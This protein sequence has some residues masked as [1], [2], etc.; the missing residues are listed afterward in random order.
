MTTTGSRYLG[1]MLATLV[2]DCAGVPHEHK[3]ADEIAR[4]LAE[5]SGR[6]YLMGYHDPWALRRNKEVWVAEPR[7]SDDSELATALGQSL[8]AHPEFD[9]A[10]LFGRMRSF[11]IDRVSI[12]TDGPAY[13]HGRTLKSA[14]TP[15]TYEASNAAFDRGE[16]SLLP[17]NG[18][19]MRNAA[20]PLAYCGNFAQLVQVSRRQSRITH[21]NDACIGACIA[22]SIFVS[23]ILQG[24]PPWSAWLQTRTLLSSIRDLYEGIDKILSLVI[25]EPTE[26]EIWPH[27]GEVTLSLRVAVWATCTAAS[28]EDGITKV[29]RIGG[30]TDT[31]GAI[32]GPALGAH[33]GDAG[34]PRDWLEQL[35]EKAHGI[36]TGLARD[37]HRISHT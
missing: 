12:L 21:R 26:D 3:R 34:I 18:S 10:D 11:M 29:I 31:Y 13:G 20:V 19:L 22:H 9:A 33:F 7:P 36:M 25:D 37:L 14:L 16:V 23:Q 28:F 2:G 24:A 5:R 8:V 32:A 4:D 6:V 27:A 15:P 30:D 35:P 1:A 17:T